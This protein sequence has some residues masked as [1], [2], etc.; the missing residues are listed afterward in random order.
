MYVIQGQEIVQNS[1]EVNWGP[2]SV[3]ICTGIPHQANIARSSSIVLSVV[4]S[5]IAT[6]SISNRHSK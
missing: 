2:L 1:A 4:V 3:T 5:S 6:T